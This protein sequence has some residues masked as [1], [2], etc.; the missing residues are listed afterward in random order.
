MLEQC[1]MLNNDDFFRKLDDSLKTDKNVTISEIFF[2]RQAW[3][4]EQLSKD[5]EEKLISDGWQHFLESCSLPCYYYRSMWVSYS[6][7]AENATELII[8]AFKQVFNAW[9]QEPYPHLWRISFTNLKD[10]KGLD[11]KMVGDFQDITK[12]AIR[13]YYPSE[14][15]FRIDIDEKQAVPISLS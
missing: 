14:R 6:V 9:E 13:Y 1:Y 5:E 8:P 12:N 7:L 2:T 15:F 4:N 10:S 11:F 3:R